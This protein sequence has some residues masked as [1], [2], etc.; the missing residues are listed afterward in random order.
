M[1]V[2]VVAQKEEQVLPLTT[3]EVE[4]EV[5]Q[6]RKDGFLGDVAEYSSSLVPVIAKPK[7]EFA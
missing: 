6:V 1:K 3:Q 2:L 7:N 5:L 4:L